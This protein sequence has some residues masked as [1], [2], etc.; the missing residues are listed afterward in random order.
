M[1]RSFVGEGGHRGLWE[2]ARGRK[3]SHREKERDRMRPGKERE[4]ER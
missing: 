3:K 2:I 1:E 4:R